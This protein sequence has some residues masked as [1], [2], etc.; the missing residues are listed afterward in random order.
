MVFYSL[1]NGSEKVTF[2]IP[3]GKRI[4]IVKNHN[5]FLG[6]RTFSM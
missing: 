3:S 5:S 4:D 1:V 6:R 2:F